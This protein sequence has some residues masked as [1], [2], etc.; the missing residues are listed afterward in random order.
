MSAAARIAV[1]HLPDMLLVP[2]ETVFLVD[3]RAR[4]YRLSASGRAVEP[5]IVD[6]VKRNKVQTAVKGPLKAGDKVTL[7]R[8][9][10][11]EQAKK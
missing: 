1:G 5:V 9:D 2:T 4:V 3:G 7:T 6:V 10:A 8:P 11:G